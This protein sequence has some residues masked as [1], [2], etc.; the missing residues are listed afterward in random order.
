MG[1]YDSC[2][3]GY[4]VD[5]Y[6]LLDYEVWTERQGAVSR[7]VGLKILIASRVI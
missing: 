3:G 5:A 7:Q 4:I 1:M 2:W 6:A